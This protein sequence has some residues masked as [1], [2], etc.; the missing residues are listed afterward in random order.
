MAEWSR[1]SR[2]SHLALIGRASRWAEGCAR[3]PGRMAHHEPL[4]SLSWPPRMSEASDPKNI[5]ISRKVECKIPARSRPFQYYGTPQP[6]LPMAFRSESALAC[7]K[8]N[9]VRL[10]SE[11]GDVYQCVC[12]RRARANACELTSPTERERW[13][14]RVALPSRAASSFVRFPIA[15]GP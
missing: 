8:A 6:D 5:A 3:K 2:T 11:R 13:V 10:C 4:T 15:S 12:A 9:V 14:R 7:C 1:S